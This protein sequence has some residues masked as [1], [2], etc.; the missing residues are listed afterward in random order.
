MASLDYYLG[1][2]AIIPPMGLGSSYI[3]PALVV[4]MA[5]LFGLVVLGLM[6]Q[7]NIRKMA[8]ASLCLLSLI[9]I[10]WGLMLWNVLF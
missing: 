1:S 9:I 5:C 6:S 4:S 7:G 8:P 10:L 2:M 3:A